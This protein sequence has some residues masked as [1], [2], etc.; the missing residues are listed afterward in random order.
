MP[1]GSGVKNEYR[2][3]PAVLMALLT[4][5]ITPECIAVA[6]AKVPPPRWWHGRSWNT[7]RLPAQ[8]GE[9]LTKLKKELDAERT[10]EA[11]CQRRRRERMEELAQR[12]TSEGEVHPSSSFKA[13]DD[14]LAWVQHRRAQLERTFGEETERSDLFLGR[15]R[16]RATM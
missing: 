2:V 1:F 15:L 12:Q 4:G 9:R 3:D 14:E 8:E 13:L 10:F 11:D 6:V 16:E 7:D 5:A